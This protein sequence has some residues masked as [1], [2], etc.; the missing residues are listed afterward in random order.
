MVQLLLTQDIMK[1]QDIGTPSVKSH[2]SANFY[3]EGTEIATVKH[4]KYA[5]SALQEK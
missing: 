5:V 2:K 4:Q 1:V 3:N